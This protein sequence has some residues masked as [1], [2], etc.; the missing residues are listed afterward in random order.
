MLDQDIVD[1]YI[2]KLRG[3]L[4]KEGPSPSATLSFPLP[5]CDEEFRTA[6]N[7]ARYKSVLC[8]LENDMRATY[9]YDAPPVDKDKPDKWNGA[10]AEA[11]AYWR[12]RLFVLLDDMNV[13]IYDE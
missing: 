12:D 13:S 8:D 3:A 9:K 11:T 6:V 1:R 2:N 7:G 10:V 4:L 5:S